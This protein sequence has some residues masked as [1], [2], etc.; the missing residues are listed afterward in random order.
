MGARL[1]SQAPGLTASPQAS[2]LTC[3]PPDTDL[4]AVICK[5]RL[6]RDIHKRY[7]FYQLLRATKF[8]HSGRVIH[9]DQKVSPTPLPLCTHR[10]VLKPQPVSPQLTSSPPAVQ[11]S[12][13]CQLP[14]EAL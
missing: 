2:L 1:L 4:H 10:S 3:T 6:L 8:I 5:G 12:P 9:R 11:R 13:G 14:G 7:I